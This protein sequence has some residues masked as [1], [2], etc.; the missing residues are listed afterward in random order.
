MK[1]TLNRFWA[2]YMLDLFCC[3]HSNLVFTNSGPESRTANAALHQILMVWNL[4]NASYILQM[5]WNEKFKMY[6]IL[7]FSICRAAKVGSVSTTHQHCMG[8]V[9]KGSVRQAGAD[10]Q[11]TVSKTTLSFEIYGLVYTLFSHNL[12]F[13]H[14]YCS[15]RVLTTHS[16]C[17]TFIFY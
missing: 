8:T 2:S 5:S 10:L 16:P 12:H 6:P 1:L 7:P 4:A 11:F 14:S 9:Y 3:T 15:G 13:I 17:V